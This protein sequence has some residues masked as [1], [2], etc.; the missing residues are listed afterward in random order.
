MFNSFQ[1][2]SGATS[3]TKF[4][5]NNVEAAVGIDFVNQQYR[6]A[7]QPVT[8]AD[9]F[10]GSSPDLTYSTTGNSTMVN[11]AGNIVWA[12]H[13]LVDYSE[14][15]SQWSGNVGVT[16]DSSTATDPLGGS[17]ASTYSGFSVGTNSR[18]SEVFLAARYF[19]C[20]FAIWL[21]GTAG[22]TIELELDTYGAAENE[23]T[24]TGS[25]QLETISND[26]PTTG[27]VRIINRSNSADVVSVWG[28]HVY[29][30]DLGGMAPVPGAATGFE[31]YVPT[32]GSAVYLP[33]VGHH[34][35]NGSTWV[36]EGL[37]IE[38]EPRTNLLTYSADFS[39]S[40]W[41]NP[42]AGLTLTG[43]QSS[44]SGSNTAYAAVPTIG[45]TGH[46]IGQSVS[47]TA[48]TTQTLSVFVKANGYSFVR[49][50][51][52]G[53][54]SDTGGVAGNTWAIFNLT[55]PAVSSEGGG[56]T[57][58]SIEDFGDGW[59]RCS[60]TGTGT[61]TGTVNQ[62]IYVL[63]QDY[64]SAHNNWAGNGTSGVYLWGAQSEVGSAPSS[65]IPTSG[66]TVTR[67]T[68]TLDIP[69]AQFSWPEVEYIG[70][71]LVVDNNGNYVGDFNSL[72]DINSWANDGTSVISILPEDQLFI[73]RNG[74]TTQSGHRVATIALSGLTIGKAYRV[75][76]NVVE[77]SNN[78]NIVVF[79]NSYSILRENTDSSST[80]IQTLT[81]EATVTDP[82]IGLS[83][84]TLN[85]T[86]KVTDVSVREIN[87]V[88]LSFAMEGRMAYADN[89][90][91]AGINGGDQ[92]FFRI[93][94][95]NTNYILHGLST[96]G[97]RTG[98]PVA[99]QRSSNVS[100]T[101]IS[102]SGGNNDYAPGVLVPY[103]VSA[104][105]STTGV[106]GANEGTATSFT[107]TPVD[108]VSLADLS[109]ESLEFGVKYM[110]TIRQF[111]QWDKDIDE[112]GIEEAT[113]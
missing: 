51:M 109:N 75:G 107:A 64:N 99:A 49:L 93:K 83:L 50:R 67:A 111:R 28:A 96:S 26:N 94:Q 88:A 62:Q 95:S 92:Q 44:P 9:A 106:Q 78:F 38:S 18:L 47:M 63:D 113:N 43:S 66:A 72:T 7:D 19:R 89:G 4:A 14:D 53:E 39:Q 33:R 57:S 110:G 77:L 5:V 16:L 11:S 59:Y 29:R 22:E 54:G 97:T 31:T 6:L 45:T 81:F 71:E 102:S 82:I 36:N 87:P 37:L 25:W 58:A 80:G 74:S 42:S 2:G 17:T 104:R 56:L 91:G 40:S 12:P 24:F 105:H 8:F 76:V 112:T 101:L 69:P 30:S 41:A 3:L 70:S 68:Q 86:A 23:I 61:T 85:A 13:N 10:I 32:N 73:D 48:S 52:Q 55:S 60:I 46:R 15:F 20:T 21:K 34:V 1:F 79:D 103:N 65:Y 35:Y 100:G 90:L 108:S 27:R 84:N 98:Q